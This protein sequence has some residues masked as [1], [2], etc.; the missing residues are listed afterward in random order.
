MRCF[1][2]PKEYAFPVLVGGEG[3]SSVKLEGTSCILAGDSGGF[4]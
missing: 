3:V 4:V 2:A 1:H